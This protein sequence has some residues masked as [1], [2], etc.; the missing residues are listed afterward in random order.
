MQVSGFEVAVEKNFELVLSVDWSRIIVE[1][2]A[3]GPHVTLDISYVHICLSIEQTKAR[4]I[5]NRQR[6]LVLRQLSLELLASITYAS[7]H[8]V[9]DEKNEPTQFP[10]FYCFQRAIGLLRLNLENNSAARLLK[11]FTIS[12]EPGMKCGYLQ[13]TM[14][15][16][17]IEILSS[18]SGRLIMNEIQKIWSHG[19]QQSF[20]HRIW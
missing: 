11:N 4:Y 8:E 9:F 14:S 13:H 12:N 18:L 3:C 1:S 7:T 19:L 15:Q 17:S 5:S 2:V 10:E 16:H 20:L 6:V